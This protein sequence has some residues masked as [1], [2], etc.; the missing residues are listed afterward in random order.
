MSL[1]TRVMRL[2]SVAT[3]IAFALAIG[4]VGLAAPG[5]KGKNKG[6]KAPAPLPPPSAVHMDSVTLSREIDKFVADKLKAEGVT[7]SPLASDAEFLRRVY[8]DI[9]GHIPTAEKAAAFLDDRD[10]N[11]RAKLVD[12]L[13]ASEDYGKHLADIWETLL[14]PKNSD[15]RRLDKEPMGKW[16]EERF[17]RNQPWSGMVHDLLTA[18][19]DTEKNGAVTFFVANGSVDKM[20]DEVTKLFLGVQ[21]QCAQCHNH[22]F[23]EWK[24]TEYWGMAAFFMKVES[25]RPQAAAKQGVPPA[26]QE[27]DKPKRGRNAL[28]ES[29][30]I[31]APKFLAGEQPKVPASGAIRP[32]LADWLTTAQNPYFA[33]AMANRMWSQYFGRGLVNPVDDM[34]QDNP[35]S[36]PELLQELA[37]QFAKHDFDLKYLVRA[38]CNSQA[39]QRSSKPTTGNGDAP[40]SLYAHTAVK[41]LSPEQLFDS[42]GN[43]LGKP[44]GRPGEARK[45]AGGKAGPNVNAR[46]VFVAFFGVDETASATEY[47][48]GIPQA[49]NLM[50]SPRINN[51]IQNNALVRGG[52]PAHEVIE[53]LYLTTLSRRPTAQELEKMTA[54]VKKADTPA[55]GYGDIL[56]ALL[57]CSEFTLNH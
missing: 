34:H 15:N 3:M 28:P 20:T 49:L 6:D 52:K 13:L 54:F 36:H 10:P 27:S 16:L 22:P 23:T 51:A 45:A 14:L 55:K 5:N 46:T 43:V 57:N 31:V 21:L 8:L 40:P 56:W 12:E 35:A 53:K 19:G 50:N 7:P 9:T 48:S 47:Q 37:N 32:V 4:S 30:K 38:I 2:F 24:Q 44:D 11:K 42:L 41:V 33:R 29:A 18:T 26:V 17:N 39:Y 25:T 1:R